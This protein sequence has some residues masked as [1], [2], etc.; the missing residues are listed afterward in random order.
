MLKGVSASAG[1]GKL[2]VVATSNGGLSAEEWAEI[3]TTKIVSI[4]DA[5]EAAKA[6]AVAY[7]ERIK[8]ILTAAFRN[9]VASDRTTLAAML[10]RSGQRDVAKMIGDL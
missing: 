9:A 5:P 4:S 8:A 2:G 3:T 7:R 1:G 6:Q 10:E